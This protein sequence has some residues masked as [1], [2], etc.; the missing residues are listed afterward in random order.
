MSRLRHKKRELNGK[1]ASNMRDGGAVPGS[2]SANA[3]SSARSTKSLGYIEGG[4]DLPSNRL[5]RKCG[6]K[7]KKR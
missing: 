7:V 6:G 3:V 5:D 2:G 1:F 4:D